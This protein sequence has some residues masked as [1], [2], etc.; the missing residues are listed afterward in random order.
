MH[1]TAAWAIASP[2]PWFDSTSG[3]SWSLSKFPRKETCEFLQGYPLAGGMCPHHRI[4]PLAPPTRSLLTSSSSTSSSLHHESAPS[5]TR[6]IP[7]PCTNSKN[8]KNYREIMGCHLSITQT[9][10][11]IGRYLTNVNVDRTATFTSTTAL[12]S[13]LY[14]YYHHHHHHHH[15]H[16]KHTANRFKTDSEMILWHKTQNSHLAWF[17]LLCSAKA[18]IFQIISIC[19]RFHE[20]LPTKAHI[21]SFSLKMLHLGGSFCKKLSKGAACVS[22]P[23]YTPPC[24]THPQPP[25]VFL[26]NILTTSSWASSIRHMSNTMPPCK[27]KNHKTIEKSWAVI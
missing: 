21:F 10:P 23:P 1:H 17:C 16:Q 5:D 12:P 7:S 20:H 25:H 2:Y 8:H 26:L 24:A 22:P 3:L 18:P 9:Q 6:Q 11:K 4:L 14:T 15:H 13:S 19:L 27:F